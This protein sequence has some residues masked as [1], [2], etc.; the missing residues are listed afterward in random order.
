MHRTRQVAT[1]LRTEVVMDFS[2]ARRPGLHGRSGHLGVSVAVPLALALAACGGGE[3]GQAGPATGLD[4][5]DRTL[6]LT[7]EPV[8]EVGGMAASD[9]AA[10]GEVTALSFD[11]DGNL[12][13]RD[14]QADR[15]TVLD[16]DGEFLRTVGSPGEGPG[17]ISNPMGFATFGDGR[18]AIFDFGHR[19][20]VVYDESGTFVRNVAVDVQGLGVPG[21]DALAH[22]AGDIVAAITGRVRFGPAAENED[23]MPPHRPIVRFPI[24][25]EGDPQV[26][27]RAWEVPPLPESETQSQSLG[28]MRIRMP[29]DRAFVPPLNV[30]VLPDGLLA[31]VDSFGYRIKMVDQNGSVR[32]VL[33]R[34]IPPTRVTPEIQEAERARRLAGIG[35]GGGP[36]IMISTSDGRTSGPDADQMR[37]FQEARLE[38]M[39]FED[40]IP[41]IEDLAVDHEGRIWVQRSSG[42][43]GEPGPTD[44]ITA[45]GR[46]LGT[47]PPD[48]LRIP[49]A[50]G[51]DGLIARVETD[52]FDVPT[53]V[54]ERLVGEAG[55]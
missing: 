48:G 19:A 37:A 52:E 49:A 45:D 50:F 16:S 44:L 30:D 54:V 13:I 23:T 20:W 5:P 40:V 10:F 25:G 34:P 51:P 22:P 1:H 53:V 6:E 33:E 43:P 39:L 8:Y 41:V 28:G 46:Y 14:T 3:T 11:A 29:P 55:G 38:T 18:V 47:V 7:T 2:A 26:V 4:A 32:S 27:Y 35:E 12:Y 31:V 17:E 9:W 36:R 24:D 42:T 21:R 15:I